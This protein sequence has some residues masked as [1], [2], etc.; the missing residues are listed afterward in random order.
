MVFSSI[1]MEL[2]RAQPSKNLEKTMVFE[3]FSI[4]CYLFIDGERHQQIVQK[5]M[6]F[7]VEKIEKI[8]EKT[9]LDICGCSTSFFIDFESI[10][11]GFWEALGVLGGVKRG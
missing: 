10:L 8:V 2:Q 11:G 4:C 5:S 9:F 6:V 7:E 3:G 1:F